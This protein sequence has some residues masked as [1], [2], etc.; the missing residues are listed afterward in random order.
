MHWTL[1]GNE[2]KKWGKIT[3][4]TIIAIV[5][6]LSPG[7]L[8]SMTA[9]HRDTSCFFFLFVAGERDYCTSLVPNADFHLFFIHICC[10]PFRVIFSVLAVYQSASLLL[11]N[12]AERKRWEKVYLLRSFNFIDA[13]FWLE[14]SFD[15]IEYMSALITCYSHFDPSW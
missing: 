8:T 9:A 1:I 4:E 2:F 14:M 12:T 10:S 5:C 6:K 11:S 7:T 15:T 13:P 3:A